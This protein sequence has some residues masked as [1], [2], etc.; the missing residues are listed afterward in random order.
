MPDYSKGKIY[1]IRNKNDLSAVY[2]GSTIQS[3]AVRLGEHKRDSKRDGYIKV[4]FYNQIQDWNDWYIEL[5]EN[6]PCFSIEELRKREGEVIREIG[7]LNKNI[8]GRTKTDYDKY[9]RESHKEQ[10]QEKYKEY[11]R[12]NQQKERERLSKYYEKVRCECGCEVSNKYNLNTHLKSNKH[13]K[14]MNSI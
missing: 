8:A 1:T 14:S 7:T 5:Y 11:Y 13:L 6:F 2:V 10:I 12:E 4:A 3:L 9:Y